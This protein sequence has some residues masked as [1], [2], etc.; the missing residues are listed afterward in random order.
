M[1]DRMLYDKAPPAQRCGGF[2]Y[3]NDATT[4]LTNPIQPF[5][6]LVWVHLVK[7]KDWFFLQQSFHSQIL[8]ELL[9][10]VGAS[11]SNILFP[12]V[13]NLCDHIS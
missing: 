4:F 1:C 5:L 11:H 8:F 10:E 6:A 3:T 9:Q 12:S 13:H 7:L 2:C